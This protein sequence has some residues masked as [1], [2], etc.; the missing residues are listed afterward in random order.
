M[1]TSTTHCSL[2]H[3]ASSQAPPPFTGISRAV[4]AFH[5][6]LGTFSC[7]GECT[8]P[9]SGR[10]AVHVAVLKGKRGEKVL[11]EF[12]IQDIIIYQYI[13]IYHDALIVYHGVSSSIS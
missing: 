11:G 9:C 12:S 4:V 7:V 13:I 6:H 3:C 10:H 1:Y 2:G 5:V 8:R